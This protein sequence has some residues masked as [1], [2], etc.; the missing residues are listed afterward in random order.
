MSDRLLKLLTDGI[1]KLFDSWYLL[2]CR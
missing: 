1:L 2:F